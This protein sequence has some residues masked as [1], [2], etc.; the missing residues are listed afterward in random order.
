M[1]SLKWGWER[2]K[3][4]ETSE[5]VPAVRDDSGSAPAVAV[6]GGG[7]KAIQFGQ[8]RGLIFSGLG[9][10]KSRPTIPDFCPAQ[11]NGGGVVS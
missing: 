10:G 8:A 2:G 3:D 11:R 6:G 1:N 7:S 9:E 4:G 5:E